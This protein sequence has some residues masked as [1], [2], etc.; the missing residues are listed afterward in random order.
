MEC[1][2][3][4]EFLTVEEMKERYPD[5]WLLLV[6][7]RLSASTELEAG[8]VVVHSRCRDDIHRSL[9]DYSGHLGIHFT[10][11]IPDDLVVVL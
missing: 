10:G 9:R 2:E 11:Q 5:E 1:S 8:K 4:Q 6:D 3:Q 7:C